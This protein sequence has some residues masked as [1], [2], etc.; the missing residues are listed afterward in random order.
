[1]RKSTLS[2]V[3]GLVCAVLAGVIGSVVLL[4]A[5]NTETVVVA[6]RP[7]Y[8]YTR[9]APADVTTVTLPKTAGIT[10]MATNPDAV[11]GK[12]LSF[13]VPKGDPV[14]TADLNPSGGSFST[15]LTQYTERT[16]QTG[17]LMALPVQTP[18]ASV[19]NPGESIA[20]LVTTQTATGPMLTTIE[21]VPVLNV[22]AP[23]KGGAPTALL[24]FVSEQ[25]YRVLAPA[26]LNN[27]VQIGLIPQ[28]G[29]FAAPETI[30]LSSAAAP[31]TASGNT[32]TQVTTSPPPSTGSQSPGSKAGGR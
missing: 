20:L 2:F 1:M 6:T 13:A 17:M 16:G 18:L 3:L 27:S 28:N 30:S 7:L 32:E 24:L 15:F 9:I 23:A 14:T 19:V 25:D 10:G 26:I 12:Y 31:T 11:V 22:L 8:P 29:T 4:R 5:A 21:P